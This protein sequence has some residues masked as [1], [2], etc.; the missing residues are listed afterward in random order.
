[1][2]LAGGSAARPARADGDPA[3]D[4]FVLQALFLPQDAG[5]SAPQTY[6]RFLGQELTLAYGGP[7]LV[8]MPN[9]YGVYRLNGTR[10]TEIAAVTQAT[11][12]GADLGTAA[13]AAIQRLALAAGRP[14]PSPSTTATRS[15]GGADAVP[16]LVFALGA[17]LIA[18]A[19]A[20]SL[21]VRPLRAGSLR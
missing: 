3:S 15:T 1:L 6:A 13:L 16:W 20:W 12:P 17:A 21:R 10:A 2:A 11:A 8:A 4:V 19:W 18:P 5:A 9:G 14:L 7:L